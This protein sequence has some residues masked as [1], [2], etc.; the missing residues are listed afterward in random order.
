M[1]PANSSGSSG[2]SGGTLPTLRGG[3]T[4]AVV[5]PRLELVV[6]REAGQPSQRSVVLDGELFRLGSHAS[7]DLVLTDPLV[8]RFHCRLSRGDSGWA[9]SDNGSLNG[10]RVDGVRVRDADLPLPDCHIELGDSVVRVRE[11]GPGGVA[12]V[13]Q[14]SSFGEL[15]GESLL[16]R[17]LF[18]VLEKVSASD[19]TVLLEGESGTG[20]ELVATEIARRGPRADKP[21]LIVDCGAISP[22]LI[23]SELFGHAKGAFTGADRMRVGAFEAADG[24]TIFLDE[25]GEMPLDM[26]PKL[27]RAI[28]AREIRRAGENEPRKIDVRVI[29]A[30]NRRLESEVNHGAFREDLYFRLSVVTVR[31]PP[32]RKRLGDLPL[33]VRVLLRSMNNEEAAH[34]FTPE[35]LADMQR[36]DWP[37]NVRELRNY[38]ERSVVL[39]QAAPASERRERVSTPVKAAAAKTDLSV[40]FKVAKEQVISEFEKRYL[41]A[42]IDA[43]GGNISKA[44]RQ[45]K[46]DRMYLYRLLQRYDLRG[47]TLKD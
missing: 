31:L 25:I 35:V 26:Q 42:L 28:E 18:G 32:L 1:S 10:T 5:I 16:M 21:F 22:N 15:Y 34:L 9:M 41:K 29:A 43:A 8:S 2:A 13:P 23:E 47:G 44:A 4:T 46:M 11:L 20:K 38:V 6:V 3:L 36:H 27:L 40:P 14:W 30:T 45:A 37:G 19:A 24:G 12:P 7:N 17:Q 39:E 33:L